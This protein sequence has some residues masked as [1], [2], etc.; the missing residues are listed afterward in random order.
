MRFDVTKPDGSV[1]QWEI[2]GISEKMDTICTIDSDQRIIWVD[3]D[4][5]APIDAVVRLVQLQ[6]MASPAL[7]PCALTER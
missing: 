2:R 4:I 1:E 6:A 7:A 3:R 5:F